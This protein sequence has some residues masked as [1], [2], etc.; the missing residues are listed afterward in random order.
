LSLVLFWFYFWREKVRNVL[1]FT[2]CK[3][4][5]KLT[6]RVNF[7]IVLWA[8]FTRADPDS[9]KIQLSRK[10]LFTLLEFAHVKARLKCWWNLALIG[11]TF[12]NRGKL[13]THT[14]SDGL[15]EWVSNLVNVFDSI[16]NHLNQFILK[17]WKEKKDIDDKT[18]ANHFKLIW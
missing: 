2:A 3:M 16:D 15:H 1:Q 11:L 18:N 8:A 14:L 4:L 17:Q 12:N 10:Y 6:P 9:V 13:G 5:V 7:I